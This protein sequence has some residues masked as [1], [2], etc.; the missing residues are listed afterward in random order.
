MNTLFS[1]EEARKN[2][3]SKKLQ[4]LNDPFAKEI[5]RDPIARITGIERKEIQETEE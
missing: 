4:E 1:A 2:F 3:I 5:D